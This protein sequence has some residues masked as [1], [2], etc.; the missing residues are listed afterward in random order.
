MKIIIPSLAV[1]IS[2]AVFACTESSPSSPS[3]ENSSSSGG[4]NVLSSSSGVTDSEGNA[5][6]YT[7]EEYGVSGFFAC[8]EALDP[9]KRVTDC[10]EDGGTWVNACPSG[11][12]ATCISDEYVDEVLKLYA[13]DW[14][15]GDLML[16]NADGSIDDVAKGGA[17]GPT[18][19]DPR[20]PVDL[21]SMCIN[22]LELPTKGIKAT[23]PQLD[24]PAP[25]TEK[26]PN[27]DLVCYAPEVEA[28]AY[29]YGEMM[30][31]Y[32]CEMLGFEEYP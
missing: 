21:A 11:E 28:I 8:A 17:C 30:S 23:C 1:A 26:C 16:E 13:E 20:I 10:E 5:C 15:C 24:P 25:F 7:G 27:A 9:Q 3:D 18:E 32:T 14:T 2:L 29:Y 31:L 19:I 4:S 22:F 6:R 12:N